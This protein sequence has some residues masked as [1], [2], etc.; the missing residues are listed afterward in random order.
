MRK[1]RFRS[2][3]ESFSVTTVQALAGAAFAGAAALTVWSFPQLK[4]YLKMKS[5]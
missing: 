3:R 1:L 5:M 4:R 2:R